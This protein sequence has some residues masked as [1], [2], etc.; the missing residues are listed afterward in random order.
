[1]G[2]VATSDVAAAELVEFSTDSDRSDDNVTE[3]LKCQ[4]PNFPTWRSGHEPPTRE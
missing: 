3:A 4:T 2:S 1:M